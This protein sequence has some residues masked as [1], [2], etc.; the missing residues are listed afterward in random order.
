MPFTKAL[1]KYLTIPRTE[2]VSTTEIVGRM[3]LLTTEHHAKQGSVQNSPTLSGHEGVRLSENLQELGSFTL[4]SASDGAAHAGQLPAAPPPVAVSTEG[5][6]MPRQL[7]AWCL[8]VPGLLVA[9]PGFERADAVWC[10]WPA[11][12]DPLGPAGARWDSPTETSNGAPSM[13][14]A[15][16]FHRESK[17]MTTSHML[18]SFASGCHSPPKGARVVYVDGGWDMFHAGA[19]WSVCRAV[20]CG[21]RVHAHVACRPCCRPCCRLH[22][23][24]LHCLRSTHVP[25]HVDFLRRAKALGDFLLV[26]VHNDVAVNTARGSNYPIMNLNERVLSVSCIRLKK[27]VVVS[28]AAKPRHAHPPSPHALFFSGSRV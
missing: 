9:W 8:V 26:G 2:G 28:F 20:Y 25:G 24:R 3:L 13:R 11:R 6:V 22:C 5:Q 14:Q 19:S 15:R 23:R 27:H 4:S 7:C 10:G 16:S 21:G 1:G 17:F 12:L 18:R